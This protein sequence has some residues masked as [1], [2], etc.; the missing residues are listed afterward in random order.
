MDWK[1]EI[2]W[3]KVLIQAELQGSKSLTQ[4]IPKAKL[5]WSNPFGSSSCVCVL[6]G[7]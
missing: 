3:L 5:I 6:S 7:K 2:K 1:R 4:Y